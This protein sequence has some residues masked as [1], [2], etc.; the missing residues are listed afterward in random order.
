[1]GC[2]TSN[3]AAGNQP[4]SPQT[5]LSTRQPHGSHNTPVVN[6]IDEGSYPEAGGD[7]HYGDSTP[8]VHAIGN[9]GDFSGYRDEDTQQDAPTV[10]HIFDNGSQEPEAGGDEVFDDAQVQ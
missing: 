9:Q 6:W 3:N 8:E 7:L 1:M 10:N 4:R 2:G 5:P